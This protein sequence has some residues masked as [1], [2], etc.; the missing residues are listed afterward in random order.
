MLS[1]AG[2]GV[3]ALACLV[4]ACGSPSHPVA[5][6]TSVTPPAARAS[7]DSA[8]SGVVVD[9]LEHWPLSGR[10]VQIGEQRALTDEQGRFRIPHVPAQYDVRVSEA[11]GSWVTLYRGVARRDPLLAHHSAQ[12]NGRREHS[13]SVKVKLEGLDASLLGRD[14]FIVQVRSARTPDQSYW[15]GNEVLDLPP[16]SIGWDGPETKLPA[17]VSVTRL[18]YTGR[19]YQELASGEVFAQHTMASRELTLE[20][21]KTAQATLTLAALPAFHVAVAVDGASTQLNWDTSAFADQRVRLEYRW[22][23]GKFGSA[24]DAPLVSAQGAF[25]YWI[26]GP[27]GSEPS[28]MLCVRLLSPIAFTQR[29]GAPTEQAASFSLDAPPRLLSPT[30]A[31]AFRAG[32]QRARPMAFAEPPLSNESR[33]SWQGPAGVTRVRVA[34]D[35]TAATTP[36]FDVYTTDNALDA[37][38]FTGR[39]RLSRSEAS[40]SVQLTHFGPFTT[41]DAAVSGAGI[42]ARGASELRSSSSAEIPIVTVPAAPDGAVAPVV[43]IPPGVDRARAVPWAPCQYPPGTEIG[44]GDRS[45]ASLTAIN[46]RLRHFPELAFEAH[47]HC[48]TNCAEAQAFADAEEAFSKKHP[49]SLASEPLDLPVKPPPPLPPEAERISP[50]H[51]GS[52]GAE[53]SKKR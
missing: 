44:C 39:A 24:I 40:Y 33:F 18:H 15:S 51:P 46:N 10:S 50:R 35:S 13:G 36:S 34:A 17:E 25:E 31:D 32:V 11:D 4:V 26:D 41:V 23:F 37:V 2:V 29:C 28:R 9:E 52:G 30:S 7:V 49:G 21:G 22:V 27:S 3:W 14:V 38:Q 5:A 8:V 53:R 47:I 6:G 1:R 48:V 42:A 12:L 16:T 45:W 20:A 43:D 19:P